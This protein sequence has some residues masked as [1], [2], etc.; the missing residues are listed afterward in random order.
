MAAA[1]AAQE[2]ANWFS[3]VTST[4]LFSDSLRR[5]LS[6]SFENCGAELNAGAHRRICHNDSGSATSRG[7]L[8]CASD[9]EALRPPVGR[10]A[11]VV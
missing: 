10:R 6:P 7:L 4:K 3:E 2:T 9:L 5:F 1:E 11:R 8:L